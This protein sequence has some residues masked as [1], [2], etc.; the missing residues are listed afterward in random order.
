[1]S[2]LASSSKARRTVWV[3]KEVVKGVTNGS[4]ATWRVRP[5]RRISSPIHDVQA[6][7]IEV[8]DSPTGIQQWR[9]RLA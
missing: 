5:V 7:S 6:G 3:P 1:M 9:Q 2:K 8:G 4:S